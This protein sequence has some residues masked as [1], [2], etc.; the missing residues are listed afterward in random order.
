MTN[1]ESLNKKGYG[2]LSKDGSRVFMQRCF[3]CDRENYMPA[4]ASGQCA[5]CEYQ[6]KKE[7]LNDE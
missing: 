2:F 4:V 5:W 6:A 7:D 1:E 3:Q